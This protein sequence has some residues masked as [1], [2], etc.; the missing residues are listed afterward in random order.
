MAARRYRFR[1]RPTL[2]TTIVSLVLLT[3]A[4]V[5]LSAGALL[6]S[7]ADTLLHHARRAALS[8]TEQGI[9]DYLNDGPQFTTEFAALAERGLLPFDDRTRLAGMFAEQLRVS[10]FLHAVGYGDV[11]GW[12]AGA[13]RHGDKEIVQ[14]VADPKVNGG[15]P[16]QFAVSADGARSTPSVIEREPYLATTRPWFQLGIG[17]ASLAWTPFYQFFGDPG[18]GISCVRRVTRPGESAPAGV[19]HADL[20]VDGIS[21]FLSTLQVGERGAVF[22]LDGDGHRVVTPKGRYV[23]AAAE[24]IDAAA[25]QEATASFEHPAIVRADGRYYEAVFVP[26]PYVTGSGITVGIVMDRAEISQGAYRHGII[27]TG[28]ALIAI[29]LAMWCARVLSARVARPIVTIAGDLAKVGQFSISSEPAPQSFIREVSD[30]GASVDRMKASLRSFGRYVPADLVRQLLSHGQEAELGVEIRRLSMFFSD[31]QDFTTMSEGMEPSRLVEATG[32]YLQLMTGA[33]IRHGGTVDKFIGDGIMAFFNAPEELPDHPRQA[34]LA[35]LAAQRLLAEQAATAAQGEPV[36]RTRIGLGLGDVLVGN[37]G[38]PERFAY[39][40]LGD[41]V[42]LASRLEG[43]N[44]VYGTRIMASSALKDEAGDG[45]EWRRLDRVA[46]KGRRQGTLIYELLG[47]KTEVAADILTARDV[48]ERGLVAYFAGAFDAAGA[49]FDEA[50]RLRPGDLAAA[51]LGQR[52]HALADDP[53]LSWDGVHV[54]V[55]K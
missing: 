14:Y 44:K 43:L 39:T 52:A 38:T 34:C 54:M 15:I 21:R 47:L 51:T 32:R 40:L 55:E 13:W 12:Y 33:I 42:N 23:A 11:S 41:E 27:A 46:V 18:S 37:I 24:A 4:A 20:H 28:V 50:A 19:F 49:L 31:V 17:T 30:L 8:A 53:P 9:R 35:A 5:G 45:F 7:V 6:Y 48:Y 10:P 25:P 22:V 36:F 3:A 26:V 2:L 29:L 1:L 16:V